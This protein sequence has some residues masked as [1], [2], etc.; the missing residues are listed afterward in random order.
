V[1]DL[2]ITERTV[3]G[4]G[5]EACR[6]SFEHVTGLLHRARAPYAAYFAACHRHPEPE[7]Q[8]DLVLGTWGSDDAQD[9]VTFSCRLRGAGAMA[10]DATVATVSDDPI[11]GARL[12]REA[13]LSHPWIDRFW[14]A[15]DH[16]AAHD[17]TI[18][19]HLGN[20]PEGD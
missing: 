7:A 19:Q 14:E 16:L 5:C 12:T 9:H 20:A 10:V 6:S 15:V 3:R 11:L 8:I 2:E 18:E 17:P 4:L 13:A 1:S